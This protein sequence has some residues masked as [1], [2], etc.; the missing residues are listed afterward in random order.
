[1]LSRSPGAEQK[2]CYLI[3]L[4]SCGNLLQRVV[5]LVNWV[6]R[7]AAMYWRSFCRVT[8]FLMIQPRPTR[9]V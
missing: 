8:E 1:M 2:R 6:A 7:T 9:T 4:P 3:L 5:R